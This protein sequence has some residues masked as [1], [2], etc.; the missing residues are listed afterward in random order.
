VVIAARLAAEPWAVA[1]ASGLVA[2]PL[3][4]GAA[5]R[6]PAVAGGVAF[7][8]LAAA[9][10]F[11]LPLWDA[12]WVAA[13]VVA[14]AALA[15]AARPGLVVLGVGLGVGVAELVGRALLP[16]VARAPVWVAPW[17][18]VG[19]DF[20][21]VLGSSLGDEAR[22]CALALASPVDVPHAA[23]VLHLGDS[24]VF[25]TGVNPEQAVVAVLARAE[26]E[27]GHV[28]AAS[29]GVSAD[30]LWLAARR[31]LPLAPWREVVL[32]VFAGNDL[33]ELDW[34]YLCCP[35]GPLLDASLR[36]RCESAVTP[37][38]ASLWLASSPPPLPVRLGGDFSRVLAHL[39]ARW[40]G[41]RRRHVHGFDDPAGAEARARPRLVRI[42]EAFAADV[43]A[44]GAVPVIVVLPDVGT[45]DERTGPVV[46]ALVAAGLDPID[47]RPW[48]VTLGPADRVDPI[49]LSPSGHAALAAWLGPRLAARRGGP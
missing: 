16:D 31:R 29:P 26:P 40:S 43:R 34:P 38:P 32:Y 37:A 21:T 22:A 24:L 39:D 25:G 5:V 8:V 11:R 18:P 3:L 45:P 13:L 49:H 9:A 41:W 12:V 17:T 20:P 42:A 44:A 7:G 14:G 28:V 19:D 15:R 30:V 10:W 4:V 36:P 6:R 2:G 27:A 23:G 48:A 46:A 35:G 33:S 47:A 1:G